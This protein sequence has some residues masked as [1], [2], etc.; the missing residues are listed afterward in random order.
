MRKIKKDLEN[1]TGGTRGK[2]KKDN[3]LT[4]EEQEAAWKEIYAE[5]E[6]LRENVFFGHAG[7][8]VDEYGNPIGIVMDL[9]LND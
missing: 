1:I 5:V 2:D 6:R 8:E 9:Y 4:P 3:P 7:F